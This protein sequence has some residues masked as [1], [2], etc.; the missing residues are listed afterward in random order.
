LKAGALIAD[1]RNERKEWVRAHRRTLVDD[2]VGIGPLGF[3]LSK[4]DWLQCYSSGDFAYQTLAKEQY[5]LRM[6]TPLP[7]MRR[8]TEAGKRARSSQRG[9]SW[10]SGFKQERV[11]ETT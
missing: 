10:L 1:G 6:E 2:F 5:M 4:Q 9:G 8:Q 11:E 3:M 7:G